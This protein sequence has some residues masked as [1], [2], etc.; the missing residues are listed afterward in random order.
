VDT[1]TLEINASQYS[2][3]FFSKCSYSNAENGIQDDILW[4]GSEQSGEGVSVSITPWREF[5]SEVYRPSYIF[6]TRKCD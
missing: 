3:I 5:A 1:K 6:R 4:D 2:K